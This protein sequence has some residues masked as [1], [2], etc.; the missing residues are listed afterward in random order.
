MELS[1]QRPFGVVTGASSGIGLELAK[2]FVAHGFDLLIA[3]E[4]GDLL[5]VANELRT[6]GAEIHTLFVDLSRYEGV[7]QLYQAVRETGRAVEAIA[8]NAGVGVGG[9][10]TH[11]DLGE[12]LRSIDLNVKSTVQLAKY[13]VPGMIERG[14][15][16]ILFTSSIAAT[17]PAPYIAV[18]GAT[19]AFVQSFALS[20]RDELRDTGVTVTAL[21]PG[22][23]DTNFFDRAHMQTTKAGTETKQENDPADVARQGFEAMM[24]GR[25]QVF[26]GS[27]K[28]K[29]QGLMSRVL[30]E[31]TKARMH[32]KQT[33]PGTA[34]KH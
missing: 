26:A 31:A 21:L 24:A 29:V 9:E 18:Y 28:T 17:M 33:Q 23:T 27:L 12:E 25:Q 22:P 20:L 4:S 15:G 10:F 14:R 16:R 32:R 8:I 19:K 6:A 30:P 13:I 11:N 5:G 1:T 2:Q 34:H 7:R 3:A